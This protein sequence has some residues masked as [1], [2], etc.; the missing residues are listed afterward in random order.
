MK[1][2]KKFHKPQRSSKSRD[3]QEHQ[4]SFEG[5]SY[6]MQFLSVSKQ[7]QREQADDCYRTAMNV[8]FVQISSKQGI[9]QFKE[10]AVSD[11]VNYYKQLHDINT[12]VILCP[13]DLMP[14]Q[15]R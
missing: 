3:R 2:M 12:I 15:K 1:I 14:I 4:P 6:E 7:K 10:R 5:K 11:I 9:K 8:M 13:E